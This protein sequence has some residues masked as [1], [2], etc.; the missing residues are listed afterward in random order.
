ME[1]NSLKHCFLC[2][3]RI[4]ILNKPAIDIFSEENQTCAERPLMSAIVSILG[5]DIKPLSVH[6]TSVCEPCRKAVNEY[7]EHE[8]RL[9]ELKVE[10]ISNYN[11]TIVKYNGIPIEV[12]HEV[13]VL[14]YSDDD[15]EEQNF[16][17]Y[18]DII[19]EIDNEAEDD[20][21]EYSEDADRD[22]S[23]EMQLEKLHN[24]DENTEVNKISFEANVVKDVAHKT[25]QDFEEQITIHELDATG[26]PV[27]GATSGNE[28]DGEDNESH[29]IISIKLEPDDDYSPRTNMMKKRRLPIKKIKEETEQLQPLVTLDNSVYTC[30]LCPQAENNDNTTNDRTFDAK[31]IVLHMKTQHDQRIYVCD[32]CGKD[33]RKRNELSEHL[34]EHVALEEGDF[35]C[36]TCNRIFS[37]FRLFRIHRRM[38]YPTN[39]SWSCDEC[40]K[41]Y[42]SRNLL[43]EHM[44]THTGK[45]PYQCEQCSKSFASKYTMAAHMKTHTDRPRPYQC[46]QCTKAFFSQ[47]N[48][49]QHERTHSG[50]K[51]Y[52]CKTC[53]KGF[54]TPHNLEVH[55]IVHTGY[56][57]FICRTCGKAFARR[58]EIRDH[59]RT[60]TGERPYSC[61][62]CGANF[63]QRSNLQS[64][65]RAT[66]F[67]D[68]RHKCELCEKCFK[69]RRLL[70]YHIK[71]THTGE[72]PFKCN[73]CEAAFVYPEHFK[74]HLR[75][76]SGEKPYLCEVC[77]KAFN[78]RDNRNAHRFVHSDKKPYECLVCG[79]GFMRKPLLYA[80]M[81]SQGH[82]NDTIVVNQPRLQTDDFTL[83]TDHEAKIQC[84]AGDENDIATASIEETDGVFL[85]DLK[86]H[87]II[88]DGDNIYAT[89]ASNIHNI[90]ELTSQPASDDENLV[91]DGN[92][93]RFSDET[94]DGDQ[95]GITQISIDDDG[96]E[97]ADQYLQ[98]ITDDLDAEQIEII[99]NQQRTIQTSNGPVQLVQ[100]RIPGPDGKE[101][102]AW[103][104]LVTSDEA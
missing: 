79:Q 51:D 46:S 1:E 90:N 6:S 11:R 28:K 9:S 18:N 26:A 29:D 12:E 70:D 16:N 74:K 89:E 43:Y 91:I 92:Q 49:T 102:K 71:A 5:I 42:S 31:A 77:G 57:P 15:N 39:K 69:R 10:I 33:F 97:Y 104:N 34:D 40:G 37:N 82:L 45:R 48:L 53:G 73:V 24:S 65:K 56:K 101:D 63:S 4:G 17:Q 86:D 103:V 80:H 59:E 88:Q 94:N 83:N 3:T 93:I 61:D 100:I 30:L 81:Q 23:I 67:D 14:E 96:V 27:G 66:H 7:D 99:S 44:N 8:M 47:Q 32:V 95:M 60:H 41:K 20:Q 22:M 58:A 21:I 55:N 62:I 13:E 87:V 25:V 68:K 85:T 36:E 54:G 84:I 38:H 75:I 64:H 19:E 50:I 72:R 52:I 98:V 78:S 76:H 35:Q 2:H